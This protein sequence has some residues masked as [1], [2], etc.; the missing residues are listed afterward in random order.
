MQTGYTLLRLRTCQSRIAAGDQQDHYDR[1]SISDV[2]NIS[3]ICLQGVITS[4]LKE[5][6]IY[7]RRSVMANAE[8][9]VDVVNLLDVFAIEV[10][11]AIAFVLQADT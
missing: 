3:F 8:S 4:R 5:T 1:H 6:I 10:A 9:R 11:V 7:T 2:P